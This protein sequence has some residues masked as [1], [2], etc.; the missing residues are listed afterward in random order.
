M[1]VLGDLVGVYSVLE[2]EYGIM[3]L[4]KWSVLYAHRLQYCDGSDG[5]GTG[6][7]GLSVS[8]RFSLQPSFGS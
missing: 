7:T 5:L 8:L 2:V 6:A 3:I 4:Q 1:L